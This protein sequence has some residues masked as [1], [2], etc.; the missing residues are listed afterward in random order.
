MNILH[1]IVR[2]HVDF[3]LD[4]FV[5][6]M[7]IRTGKRVSVPTLWRS[8]AYCGITRKKLHKA[9]A[10]R[11]EL[12][13]GVFIATIGQYRTDQLVFMDESSKDERTMTR[14][15]GYSRVAV[16]NKGLKNL[17]FHKYFPR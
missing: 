13:R 1:E 5:E 9:S 12:L 4:E 14:L 10:E 8:L 3:Y 7:Q 11:S 6:K 16:R 17:L 15:Y 2:E